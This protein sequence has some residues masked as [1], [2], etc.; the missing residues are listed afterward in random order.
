MSQNLGM[1]LI[2][3]K[4]LKLIK[5]MQYACIISSVFHVIQHI[6]QVS[7]LQQCCMVKSESILLHSQKTSTVTSLQ[8]L[9]PELFKML[10][11]T[12]AYMTKSS[13]PKLITLIIGRNYHL[14]LCYRV[15][16]CT[17]F[18]FV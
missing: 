13:D 1:G 6:I 8:L 16:F 18:L 2:G 4:G 17:V 10:H 5:H 15:A 9:T 12:S 7:V 3:F 11:P 14:L